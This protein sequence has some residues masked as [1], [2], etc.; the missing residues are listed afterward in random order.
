MQST[1]GQGHREQ[2]QPG[3]EQRTGYQ[4]A[5]A[6]ATGQVWDAPV[7]APA[8][9]GPHQRRAGRPGAGRTVSRPADQAIRGPAGQVV[10][11]WPLTRHVNP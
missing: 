11:C 5:N 3:D 6:D 8:H 9:G 1:D 10:A 7:A 2:R 4:P